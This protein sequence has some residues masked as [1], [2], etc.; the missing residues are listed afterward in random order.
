MVTTCFG[1]FGHHQVLKHVVGETAAIYCAATACMVP[2]MRTCVVLGVWCVLLL[3]LR[4]L[5]R[6]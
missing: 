4:C 1:L 6:S 3:I 5:F 2:L